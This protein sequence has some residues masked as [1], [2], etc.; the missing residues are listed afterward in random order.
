VRTT[1]SITNSPTSPK[2]YGCFWRRPP[3]IEIARRDNWL[4]KLA[5]NRLS[6]ARAA[7]AL[8]DQ[9]EA[10]GHFE[11]SV[12][13][14]RRAGDVTC[15]PAGLLARAALFRE[16][17][18][19]SA[20]RRDLEEAMRIARRSEMRL[21]QCDAHLEYARLALAEGDREQARGHVVEARRL[22]NETGYGRRPEVAA[23]EAQLR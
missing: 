13:G 22:V 5:L 11:Q 4:L 19:F 2:R 17:A 15:P 20:A 6:I 8:G 16:T 7:L 12:G 21:F 14:L 23:L 1:P 18:D 9:A 3:A 10:R